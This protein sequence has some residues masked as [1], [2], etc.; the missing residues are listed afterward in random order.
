MPVLGLFL[1][2]SLKKHKKFQKL[3]NVR[4]LGVRLF[5]V[6]AT[7]KAA[8]LTMLPEPTLEMLRGFLNYELRKR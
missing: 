6:V 2:F 5:P 8:H 1:C 4:L 3:A 7:D